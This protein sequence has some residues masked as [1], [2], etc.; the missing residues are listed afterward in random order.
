MYLRGDRPLAVYIK[1]ANK[2]LTK[3]PT[4][5]IHAMTAAIDKAIKLSMQ[6]MEAYPYLKAEVQTDSVPAIL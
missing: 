4:L 3:H 1:H 5:I 6:L 2:V